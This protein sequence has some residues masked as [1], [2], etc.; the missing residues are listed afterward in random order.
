M[1]TL[2]VIQTERYEF[3][4]ADDFLPEQADPFFVG[5]DNEWDQ[6]KSYEVQSRQYSLNGV[7]VERQGEAQA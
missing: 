6:A 5:M 3:L 1:K 2:T 7:T 4:V